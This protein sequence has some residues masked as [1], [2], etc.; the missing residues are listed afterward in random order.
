LQSRDW[1][2]RF[3]D[4]DAP[5][6]FLFGSLVLALVGNG[7]YDLLTDWLGDRP[8]TRLT[9]IIIS[10]LLTLGVAVGI[11]LWIRWII[12]R[13][14]QIVL[15]L[16]EKADPHPGLI[17]LVSPNPQAAD[18]DT[19]TH[20]LGAQTLRSCW[21]IVSPQVKESGKASDLISWLNERNVRAYE[22]AIGDANQARMTYDAITQGIQEAQRAFG[23]PRAIIVDITG[24]NKPMTAGAVLACRDAGVAM[25]YM[26]TPRD[27]KGET[28]L[29]TGAPVPI[30][31][32][33]ETAEA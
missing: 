12:R 1:F 22:L 11:S 10:V 17:M 26:V 25:E 2:R 27:R 20:H 31:V 9:I 28:M 13:V 18:R 5:I 29:T 15:P 33:L 16:E 19:I 24:G 6:P 4:P 21:L 8:Q 30:Q 7:V 32:R 3:F 23:S 14:P